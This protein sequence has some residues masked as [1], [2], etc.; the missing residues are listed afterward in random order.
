MVSWWNISSRKSCLLLI[1]ELLFTFAVHSVVYCSIVH[2]QRY[3]LAHWQV[4]S[5]YGLGAMCHLY[6][7]MSAGLHFL[8]TNFI[9]S[10]NQNLMLNFCVKWLKIN[11]Y[12]LNI[13]FWDKSKSLHD[14]AD[15]QFFGECVHE[16][17]CTLHCILSHGLVVRPMGL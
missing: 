5:Y 10:L 8:P 15:V 16:C 4:R 13:W 14:L 1:W 11:I 2:R 6:S 9:Y 3:A 12:N 7:N 17:M